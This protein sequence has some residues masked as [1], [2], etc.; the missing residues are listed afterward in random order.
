M[1]KIELGPDN[2]YWTIP[3]ARMKASRDH[4][5]PLSPR[6]REIVDWRLKHT[7]GDYVFSAHGRNRPL[8]EKA[9]REILRK[10]KPGMTVHGFRSTFRDWA[11]DETDHPRDLIELCLSHQVGNAVERAYRR[12]DSL[13]KR[14]DIMEA[15]AI[16]C[17]S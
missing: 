11:G 3:A 9:M 16:Y 6:A 5:V 4:I 14:R 10:I 8:D 13:G 17:G 2:L 1:K 7:I 15:W 12:R